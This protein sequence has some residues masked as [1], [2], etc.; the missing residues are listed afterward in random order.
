VWLGAAFLGIVATALAIAIQVAVQSFTTVVHASLIYTLEPV[1]AAMFGYWLHGDRLG[2]AG[3]AGAGLIVVG[4][5]AAEI[6][7]YIGR[8]TAR[9]RATEELAAVEGGL[10]GKSR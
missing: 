1:F 9:R 8:R 6:G 3:I 10:E 4:M 5:L 7:P 2:P